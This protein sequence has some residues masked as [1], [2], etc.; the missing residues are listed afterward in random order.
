MVNRHDLLKSKSG[1]FENGTEYFERNTRYM[2][3]VCKSMRAQVLLVSEAYSDRVGGARRMAMP[4]HNRLLS[5][6][7]NEEGAFYYDF[8]SDMT[9]DDVHLPD[10]RHVS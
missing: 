8:F 2:I 10:G 4:Q 5:K 7:A 1:L 6:I 9:K 3:A